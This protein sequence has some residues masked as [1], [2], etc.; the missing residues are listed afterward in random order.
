M[1]YRGRQDHQVKLRGYRIELGEIEA[2]LGLHPAIADCVVVVHEEVSGTGQLVAYM[3]SVPTMNIPDHQ[4]LR[5]FLRS[6]LPEYM[7]PTHFVVLDAL[8]LTP[9]GKVDRR[10]LPVPELLEDTSQQESSITGSPIEEII[11]QVWCTVLQRPQI[12]LHDNFFELGGHSLLATQCI[13]RMRTL[14]QVE[15]PLR[16]IFEAPTIAELAQR[17]IQALRGERGHDLPPLQPVPRTQDLPLSFAQ[18]RLW[19]LNQLAPDNSAY[20]MPIVRHVRGPLDIRALQRSLTELV[21]RHESLRTTFAVKDDQP[22]QVIHSATDCPL[23]LIDLNALTQDQR[24]T[25]ARRLAQQEAHQPCNLIHGPLLRVRLLRMNHEEHLFLLTLHHIISDGWSNNVL[26]YELTTLYTAFVNNAPFPLAPLPLHYADYA[27][28]QRQWLRDSVLHE[29]VHYWTQRLA[30]VPAL[31]LP[32]DRPRPSVQTYRGD[33]LTTRLPI[34]LRDQLLELAHSEDVTLFMVLLAAFQVLLAR[35]SGQEDIAVGVPIANRTRAELEGLIGFFVN[36]L[37]LRTDLSLNPTFRE[38]L[39]QVREVALGAYAHQDVPFEQLVEILQPERHLSRPPLFQVMFSVQQVPAPGSESGTQTP[40]NSLKIEGFETGHQTAKF[41]LTFTVTSHAQGLDCSAEYNSDLFD[42]RTITRLFA[43]WHVLLEGLI[44]APQTPIAYLPLLTDQEQHRLCRDTSPSTPAP[45]S[46]FLDL[47]A[48]QAQATPD[49]VAV[50]SEEACLSYS[51]LDRSANQLARYL[52]GQGV[53]PEVLVGILLERSALWLIALLAVLKVGGGYVPLEKSSPPARL[54]F[55][56]ADACIAL[57]VTDGPISIALTGNKEVPMLDLAASW[58]QVRRCSDEAP[59]TSLQLDNIAYVIY[60]SGS[61]GTPKGVQVSH[62]GLSNLAQ[63]QAQAFALRRESHVLQFAAHSFDASIAEVVV[64]MGAGASLYL[65]PPARLSVG[66]ELRTLL[67]TWSISVVTLPPSVLRTLPVSPLPALET[68]VVAGEACP[69]ELVEQWAAVGRRLCNA[70]GPTEFTVCATI[71]RC[72]PSEGKPP[73]GLPIANTQVYVLDRFLQPVPPGVPG[74]LFLGGI[75]VARGYSRP[76]VTAER[77]LPHPMSRSVGARLYRTGDLVRQH[78][79]GTMEFLGRLDHQVKVRG[80]RIELGEIEAVLLR[81]ASVQEC[82][83][84]VDERLPE[85]QRLIAYLVVAPLASSPTSAELHDFASQS[86][87]EYMVPSSFVQLDELLLTA[88]G[89]VD[90]RALLSLDSRAGVVRN[91]AA[92]PRTPI[93]AALLEIWS[94]VLDDTEISIFDDFFLLGGHSL[95]ATQVIS[96]IR[97]HLQVDLS[98]PDFFGA[99]TIA[100]IADIIEQKQA[101]IV[102][103]AT[104]D[105]LA[106][107]MTELEKLSDDEVRKLLTDDN[108]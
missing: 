30:G 63:A 52:Q 27:V 99:P 19:F 55:Q 77:F 1:E 72:Q 87:P 41:D 51:T 59:G 80:Y 91:S 22:V 34:A 88:N 62:R 42:G 9:N 54:A 24:T 15:L 89:K 98:L 64:T 8:P 17:V 95:L 93:E 18:Q 84:L 79:D 86:L 50:V 39:A 16:T 46:T 108:L 26:F 6:Q 105:E 70:Y 33:F 3:V 43:H 101:S 7:L 97:T 4:Q 45:I 58:S 11:G 106:Q 96:R 47:F 68:L 10:A 12:G 32:T 60:T 57:L 92:T 67:E 102:E 65:A 2:V 29:Q 82:L 100:G 21:R 13:A 71:A 53:G 20:L 85:N 83:V 81:H 56:I 31:E 37:V 25:T 35:Y 90:R 61:T 40:E 28:W 76:D 38:V 78:A 69:V 36:T 73:I 48:T 5:Q 66:D 104:D 74:E 107:M 23:P 49:A 103:Q 44:A 94:G 14:L 75:G